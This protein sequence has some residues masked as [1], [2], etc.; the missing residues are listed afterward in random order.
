M[1][2]P[3]SHDQERRPSD[4]RGHRIPRQRTGRRRK[5]QQVR[6]RGSVKRGWTTWTTAIVDPRVTAIIPIV[7]DV[8]NVQKSMEHHF[9]AY[10]FWAPAIKDYVNHK[11]TERM[12]T[13]GHDEILR[14]CDPFSYRERLTMPK[15]IVNASGDEFFVPDS[16]QF[17]F[18]ELP[19]PKYLRYVPN[20]NHSLKGTDAV[21]SIHAFYDAILKKTPLPQFGWTMEKDG[22]I[23]V[24][25]KDAPKEVNL[26]QATNPKARDF[27]IDSIGKA[28]TKTT[29]NSESE[30]KYVA[31][32]DKPESGWT[33]FFV[34]LVYDVGG[35]FPLKFT[36]QVS[37]VPDKLPH[38]IEEYRQTLRAGK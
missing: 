25:T 30:G 13:P 38:S 33:A 8:L 19:A 21:F 15:Y 11:I 26:W 23:T 6:R 9:E 22:S 16:S 7:I 27:R 5:D 10:G 18:D 28:F 17:Y 29:L 35:T 37:I 34:E 24:T 36:T 1:A 14:I 31:T 32:V 3:A 20:A 2:S 4:G 12:D